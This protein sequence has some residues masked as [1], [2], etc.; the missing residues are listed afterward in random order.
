MGTGEFDAGSNPGGSTTS[1]GGS[2]HAMETGISSGLMG[3][4]ARTQRLSLFYLVV[5]AVE[6]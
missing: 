2:L 3:L 1:P 6:H 5:L 4:L